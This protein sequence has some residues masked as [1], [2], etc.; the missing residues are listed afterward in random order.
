MFRI[1]AAVVFAAGMF[2]VAFLLS[3]PAS[4]DHWSSRRDPDRWCP[5]G[6]VERIWRT[7]YYAPDYGTGVVGPTW[8]TRDIKICTWR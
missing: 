7:Y 8:S 2:L 6:M 3:G 5:Y 4:G 1:K